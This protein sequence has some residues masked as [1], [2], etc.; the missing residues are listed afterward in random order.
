MV[1]FSLIKFAYYPGFVEI[2]PSTTLQPVASYLPLRSD[3]QLAVVF[4]RTW[5]SEALIW[6]YFTLSSIVLMISMT[7]CRERYR[8]RVQ[9]KIR[10][11]NEWKNFLIERTNQSLIG[12]GSFEC[13][14][15]NKTASY[16]SFNIKRQNDL[17]FIFDN[18]QAVNISNDFEE[19]PEVSSR[20]MSSPQSKPKRSKR[21]NLVDML[22]ADRSVKHYKG[23]HSTR[24]FVRLD[25]STLKVANKYGKLPDIL[26]SCREPQLYFELHYH[27]YA[28][29]DKNEVYLLS[30]NDITDRMRYSALLKKN[31][32]HEKICSRLTN[33]FDR[34]L[35]HLSRQLVSVTPNFLKKQSPLTPE[36]INV[37]L[38]NFFMDDIKLSI[39]I[40]QNDEVEIVRPVDVMSYQIAEDTNQIIALFTATSMLVS[41]V[42]ISVKL[43]S[44]FTGLVT[45]DRGRLRQLIFN[46]IY[47]TLQNPT[48]S[49]VVVSFRTF[50]N[51][52]IEMSVKDISEEKPESNKPAH[53]QYSSEKLALS[54]KRKP[55]STGLFNN[56]L[57]MFIIEKLCKAL[58][59]FDHYFMMQTK[60]EVV[61]LRVYFFSNIKE[62]R[63]FST[64]F[65]KSLIL[66]DQ[67]RVNTASSRKMHPLS[68]TEQ[69]SS[70]KQINLAYL[71]IETNLELT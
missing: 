51:N 50:Y 33:A 32:V 16:H 44:N 3:V 12:T 7:F 20:K 13:Q 66:R 15:E 17:M 31:E 34:S 58:G 39:Q 1:G 45:Q 69:K 47:I 57:G 56:D 41:P 11:L 10:E 19:Q 67:D 2:D 23:R 21:R 53:F 30:F 8:K 14:D 38:M 5:C 18:L 46:T 36:S 24:V 63:M 6:G 25:V 37:S 68:I 61:G 26:R 9:H 52:T 49:R 71:V 64:N 35:D 22:N 62:K 65:L 70:L 55:K 29:E 42:S 40:I 27:S 54:D 59:P 4:R 60:S 28:Q 48:L 43:E